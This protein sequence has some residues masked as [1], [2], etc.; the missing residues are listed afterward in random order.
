[1]VFRRKF[2]RR[3]VKR[4]MVKGRGRRTLVRKVRRIAMVQRRR[5]PEVKVIHAVSTLAN[6]GTL[7]LATAGTLLMPAVSQGT[8]RDERVGD[9]IN[10]VSYRLAIK[11][12][13][14]SVS[15]D[16]MTVRLIVVQQKSIP[17]V[18]LVTPIL[19][20]ILPVDNILSPLL[21][22]R[23]RT[24]FH[25]LCDKRIQLPSSSITTNFDN[26]N[27]L[28]GRQVRMLICNLKPRTRKIQ[29]VSASS[30]V[31]LNGQMYFWLFS[32]NDLVV[33]NFTLMETLRY[34]DS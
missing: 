22:P 9:S 12:I 2:H 14:S 34:T 8:A 31:I 6:L 25:M 29:Y 7:Q 18:A 23:E 20:G 16:G 5:A 27:R 10:I 32:D 13:S 21:L 28:V 15:G 26:N 30:T 19:G 11:L 33:G 3:F 4:R 1:M 24:G 17:E